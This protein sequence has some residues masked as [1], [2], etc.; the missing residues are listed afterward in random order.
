MTII[1]RNVIEKV[2]V[3]ILS[4]YFYNRLYLNTAILE[5]RR[6]ALWY[7]PAKIKFLRNRENQAT[8]I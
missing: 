7:K 4:S 3:E 6:K 1:L 2:G 5:Y 8:R